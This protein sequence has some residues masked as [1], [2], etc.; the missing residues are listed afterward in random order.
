MVGL[1]LVGFQLHSVAGKIRSLNK[2]CYKFAILYFCLK[3]DPF[4]A[5]TTI[6]P[7]E[8]KGN[9]SSTSTCDFHCDLRH[10]SGLANGRN[11]ACKLAVDGWAVT[12]GTAWRGLGEAAQAPLRC[13]KCNSPHYERPVYQ[14]SYCIIVRCSVPVKGLRQHR[15]DRRQFIWHY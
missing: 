9:Y 10:T 6:N 12:F 5:T 1:F 8:C 4:S 14:S 3:W 7:L 2:I 13:I 11:E 15:R